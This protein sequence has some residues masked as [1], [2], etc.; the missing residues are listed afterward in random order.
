MFQEE[1]AAVRGKVGQNRRRFCLF[2]LKKIKLLTV[3]KS[4]MNLESGQ[5]CHCRP[6]RIR[7]G[8]VRNTLFSCIKWIYF[9]PKI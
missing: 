6:V 7:P 2:Y 3:P 9:T 1:E 4:K 8:A 5:G